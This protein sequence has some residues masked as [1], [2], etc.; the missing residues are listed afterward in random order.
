M[1]KPPTSSPRSLS[2]AMLAVESQISKIENTRFPKNGVRIFRIRD[3]TTGIAELSDLGE[4]P[5]T[6]E[7]RSEASPW[8]ITLG[9]RQGR[10]PVAGRVSHIPRDAC[11]WPRATPDAA[12]AGCQDIVKIQWFSILLKKDISNYAC[13][14]KM[15]SLF[16]E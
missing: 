13:T 4:F 8:P 3:S 16:K 7:N 15:S 11:G 10:F 14:R 12:M 6:S 2:S 9:T 1:R 5:M